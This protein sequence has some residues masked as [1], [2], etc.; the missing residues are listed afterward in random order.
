M[1]RCE[2][3]RKSLLRSPLEQQ[4]VEG[5]I[6]VTGAFSLAMGG[7]EENKQATEPAE[8]EKPAVGKPWLVQ[9][10]PMTNAIC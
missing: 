7:Q 10:H 1:P 2:L 4:S 9:S 6:P 5:Q 3:F 8:E